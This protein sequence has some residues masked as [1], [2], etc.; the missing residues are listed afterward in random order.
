M[1]RINEPSIETVGE[2]LFHRIIRNRQRMNKNTF[3]AIAGEGGGGK[4]TLAL[5]MAEI[6][7]PDF[8]PEQQVVYSPEDFLTTIKEAKEKGHKVIILDEAHTTVDARLYYSFMNRCVTYVTSTFRQIHTLVLIIVA[9]NINWVEKKIREQMNF[10]TV[11]YSRME[12][13]YKVVYHV[14]FYEVGFNFYDLR[15]Q[16]PYIKTIK[17]LHNGEQLELSEFRPKLA[18]QRIIDAYEKKALTYKVDLIEKQLIEVTTQL[19]GE[20]K[21]KNKNLEEI[22]D[23]IAKDK[24]LMKAIYKTKN[25]EVTIK[26]STLKS[27]FKIDELEC[28]DLEEKILKR[29]NKSVYGDLPV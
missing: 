13:G 23:Q 26:K 22:A 20:K 4:S 29:M 21:V 12:T 24:R 16:S 2:K 28:I 15:D 14:K 17:F 1:L 5:R 3:I 11:A 19:A 27:L 10:Y 9:P 18:S 8:D 25:G 6:V 7:E